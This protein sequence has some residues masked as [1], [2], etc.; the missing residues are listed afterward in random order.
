MTDFRIKKR[1]QKVKLV[2]I[3]VFL[4][5]LT[6]ICYTTFASDENLDELLEKLDKYITEAAR[7]EKFSGSVLLAKDGKPFF[8]KAYGFASRRFWV[9]NKID[10]K[11][12]LGSMNKMFTTIAVAQLAE[13]GKLS[14]TDKVGK[15]LGEKWIKP[16]NGEKVTIHHLLTHTSGLGD[17]FSNVFFQSSKLRFLSVND[18]QI[19]V[20]DM[21]LQFEPGAKWS[22]SNA[23]FILLGAII[24]KVAEMDYFEYMRKNVYNKA[25]MINSDCYEM[26]KPVPNLAIG[27]EKRETDDGREYWQNNLFFHEVKGAPAGGGFSTV[28]DLLNF[29]IALRNGTLVST[30]TWKLLITERAGP[31]EGP[32]KWGYGFII[33]NDEKL[34]RIVGHGGG[35]FGINSNLDMYLDT[36]YTAAV[37][38]NIGEGA[39]VVSGEIKNVIQSLVNKE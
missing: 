39:D 1:S 23:G 17:F 36:G 28:E 31:P 33:E 35:F 12:N 37:M 27:Y 15:Y 22:Y 30:E 8:K 3:S 11:F 13:K 34:G 14:Y 19:L 18:Y 20:K 26:D 4:F 6:F 24:E 21:E 16:E 7:S 10:T 38:S 5:L 9:P 29:E 32:K 2:Y 25:N